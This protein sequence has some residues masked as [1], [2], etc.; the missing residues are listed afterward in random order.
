MKK[1]ALVVFN[2]ELMCFTHVMLYGLD[3]A[4]K[5][6]DVKIIL[7]GAA[8][9][10]PGQLKDPEEPFAELYKKIIDKNLIDCVCMACSVKMGAAKEIEGQGLPLNGELNGHPSL[11]KYVEQGYQ[12]ITF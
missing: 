1:I 10:L 8:T 12:V 7:E 9:K 2:G 3:F 6:Y 11:S 5:G 4:A